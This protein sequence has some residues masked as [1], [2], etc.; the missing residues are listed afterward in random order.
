MKQFFIGGTIDGKPAQARLVQFQLV[1]T[2]NRPVV[3][4]EHDGKPLEIP[5]MGYGFVEYENGIQ[6]ILPLIINP[7]DGDLKIICKCCYKVKEFLPPFWEVMSPDEES[8]P[9]N[10]ET[11]P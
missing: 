10:T 6:C 3:V 8:I 2:P 5:I 9:D 7:E 4:I 1:Q 11:K